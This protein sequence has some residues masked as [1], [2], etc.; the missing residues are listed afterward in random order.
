M[1]SSPQPCKDESP[2]LS[3]IDNNSDLKVYNWYKVQYIGGA[4]WTK[5]VDFE[6]YQ[7]LEA[8]FFPRS[9][10]SKSES[11]LHLKSADKDPSCCTFEQEMPSKKS[12]LHVWETCLCLEDSH[13]WVCCS[14]VNSYDLISCCSHSRCA[15]SNKQ[16]KSDFW[17]RKPFSCM[18]S[19]TTQK[20]IIIELLM[21]PTIQGISEGYVRRC[22]HRSPNALTM[23]EHVNHMW[24]LRL[25]LCWEEKAHLK[26]FS[27]NEGT[28]CKSKL[29]FR[30]RASLMKQL[31][32]INS[33]TH[34]KSGQEFRWQK[35]LYNGLPPLP[36]A[37]VIGV[38]KK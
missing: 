16:S 19:L 10:Q 9:W 4:Q 24:K 11:S 31:G 34:K 2:D 27:D 33:R 8:L 26:N 32:W 3:T 28:A 5:L 25:C 12:P 29:N 22:E 13:T 17:R 38:L 30:V 20:N 23:S 14:Q 18:H 37:T 7:C 35:T 36:V 6:S 15:A 21:K 1:C